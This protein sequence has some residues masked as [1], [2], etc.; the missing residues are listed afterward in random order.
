MTVA[1]LILRAAA[2]LVLG[3]P[4][5]GDPAA[6]VLPLLAVAALGLTAVAVAV[7][8]AQVLATVLATVLGLRSTGSNPLRYRTSSPASRGASPMP[9]GTSDRV[10]RE[11]SPR[12]DHR[13]VAGP[14]GTP[15]ANHHRSEPSWTCPPCPS[16]ARCCTAARTSSPP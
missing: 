1:L 9:T 5:I 13:P 4:A 15:P 10:L 11:S 14:L 8:V 16:S 12:P 7:V 3:A 6:G 2:A